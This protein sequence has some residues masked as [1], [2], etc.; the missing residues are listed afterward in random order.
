MQECF[1]RDNPV[2]FKSFFMFKTVEVTIP[3][4]E[5]MRLAHYL[6]IG[7]ECSNAI[8]AHQEKYAVSSKVSQCYVFLFRDIRN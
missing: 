3:E 2:S 6:T 5:V 1:D 4:I 8:A 7:S